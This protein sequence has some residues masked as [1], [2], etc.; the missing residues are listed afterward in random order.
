MYVRNHGE[1]WKALGTT[2]SKSEAINT[3]L[4]NAKEIVPHEK[5]KE[6]LCQC[7]KCASAYAVDSLKSRGLSTTKCP[8]RDCGGSMKLVPLEEGL[9]FDSG[10]EHH[11]F[12]PS[13]FDIDTNS[14]SV[15]YRLIDT[16]DS[17]VFVARFKGEP[18]IAGSF[19]KFIAKHFHIF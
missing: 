1:Q 15:H 19:A 13:Q 16:P 6:Q 8:Q 5:K 7:S 9:G 10:G 17:G 2:P 3:A 11:R 4:D 14:G 18:D 12:I